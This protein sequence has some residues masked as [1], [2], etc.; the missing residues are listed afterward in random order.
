MDKVVILLT[1]CINPNGMS[2]TA[3]QDVNVRL[4]Q[5]QEALT[6]YLNNTSEKIVFVENS[7]F[8]ISPFFLPYITEGRLEVITFEGNTYDRAL[9][10]G[11]GEALL[12]D[13]GLRHSCWLRNAERI[14]KITGRLICLNIE[15]IVA[16]YKE[17][18]TIYAVKYLDDERKM[19]CLSQVVVFTTDFLQNYLL[20]QKGKLND[21]IHYWFEHLLYDS[22]CEWEKAGHLFKDMWIPVEL[23]GE[24]GSSGIPIDTSTPFKKGIFYMH[25]ILHRLGYYGSLAFWNYFK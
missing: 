25:Y 20:P 2:F 3:I 1:A 13:Y 10:K 18:E 9:G 11:Y 14:V 5:Y 21:N 16:S 6:W 8:D 23:K 7:G 17:P 12:I 24:S 4:R 19:E 22:A 15:A